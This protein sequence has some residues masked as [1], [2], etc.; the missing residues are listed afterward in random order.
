VASDCFVTGNGCCGVCDGPS[1]ST[2]DFI[3]YNRKF[4]GELECN[5]ARAAPAPGADVPA[6]APCP[7]V[8]DG[9][10]KYFVPEC[11]Q[12][13]CGVLDLRQSPLLACQYDTDCQLRAGTGCCWSCSPND[14]IA[15]RKDAAIEK[16]VC[17]PSA[18]IGC[19]DC[20]AP[21]MN[22]RAVCTAG[23]CAVAY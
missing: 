5:F 11:V 18:P 12:G 15:L 21:I 9:T 19:P 16:L 6:C 20:A 22:E 2:H 1:L 3:A 17:D 4:Q 7:P 13:Q 10:L 23:R 14:L 8:A